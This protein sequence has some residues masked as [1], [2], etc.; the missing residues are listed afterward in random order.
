MDSPVPHSTHSIK[1][2]NYNNISIYLANYIDRLSDHYYGV[3]FSD[4]DNSDKLR[5]LA[6]INKEHRVHIYI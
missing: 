1:Y 6:I 4:L 5:I 2:I 3:D